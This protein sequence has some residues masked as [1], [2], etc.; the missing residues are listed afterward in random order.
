MLPYLIVLLVVSYLV[1]YIY[2]I[3]TEGKKVRKKVTNI[4]SLFHAQI[5]RTINARMLFIP[6]FLIF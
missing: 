3:L 1:I 4:I 6:L 5:N 2:T